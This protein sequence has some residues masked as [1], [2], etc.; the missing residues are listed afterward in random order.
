MNRAHRDSVLEIADLGKRYDIYA[1]PEDRLWQFLWRGRRQWAQSFWAL[2]HVG[3]TLAR[4]EMVGIVGRNGAGKSTLLQLIT[5]TLEPSEGRIARHGK[6]AALLE[7]GTGFNPEFTGEENV[8]L[9]ASI[10][11][12]DRRETR[13]RFDAIAQFAD[14][15]PVLNQP[16]KTYSSGMYARLAFAV[17]AHVDADILI[18]DEIL[19]VGDAA[20]Q[21]KCMRFISEFRR[22]GAVLFVS[23]D[24]QAVI[25]LCSKAIWLE[26]GTMHAEGDPKTVCEAYT[27]ALYSSQKQLPV[28]APSR[29]AAADDESGVVSLRAPHAYASVFDPNAA[30]FGRGGARILDVRLEGDERSNGHLL[31]GGEAARL[32][33]EAEINEPMTNP[34]IG[35]F[36]KDRLG[37]ILFGENTGLTHPCLS[38]AAKPG[39]RLV[40]RFHFDLPCLG[41]GNYSITV[42]IAD[43]T[44]DSHVQHHW[45]HDAVWLE[46]VGNRQP[47]GGLFSLQRIEIDFRFEGSVSADARKDQS[48]IV[49]SSG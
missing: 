29:T 47:G 42:A 12:L 5:G 21:Q 22:S 28:L 31:T 11:G 1:R 19:A 18:I 49:G 3:L 23:H 39:D 2:R 16:V 14:I 46:V 38:R 36:V 35:F 45:I 44:I 9:A 48:N 32:T 40:A 25:G 27:A 26:H 6:I 24:V 33:V 15:G 10:L 13:A 34:I 37:Q 30:A 7:L 8:Y 4:G 41:D 17:A 43:G 20:F